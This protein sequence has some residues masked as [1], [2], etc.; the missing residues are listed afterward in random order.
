MFN[1]GLLALNWG[2]VDGEVEQKHTHLLHVSITH[3]QLDRPDIPC[4]MNRR[5]GK[6][7]VVIVEV[8]VLK[9]LVIFR[10][11]VCGH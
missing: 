8:V 10:M 6:G 1:F 4:I 7:I 2:N 5:F 3:A 9:V 11:C